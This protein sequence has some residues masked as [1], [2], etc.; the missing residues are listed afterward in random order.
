MYKYLC[1]ISDNA[2]KKDFYDTVED[3][4]NCYPDCRDA[5]EEKSDR[6]CLRRVMSITEKNVEK[7]ICIRYDFADETVSVLS[8]SYLDKFFK[9]K[10]IENILWYSSKTKTG[11]IL[12]SIIFAIINIAVYIFMLK[13]TWLFDL[14]NI[15]L[16][17]ILFCFYTGSTVNFKKKTALKL[18]EILF[19]QFGG[20]AA[21]I[22]AAIMFIYFIISYILD[23][24][25]S[26]IGWAILTAGTIA[27]V[28]VI[29]VILPLGL[30]LILFY[31]YGLFAAAKKRRKIN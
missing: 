30:N 29:A 26:G 3:V 16:L 23:F 4:K 13:N 20:I 12:L 2:D 28:Y 1:V 17:L 5:P 21:F 9:G 10:E 27:E 8:D 11:K 7:N 24:G 19:I 31:V 18:E 15:V 25:I 22:A 14:R 6:S